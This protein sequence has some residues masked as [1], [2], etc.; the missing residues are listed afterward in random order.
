MHRHGR[1]GYLLEGHG[2]R[3]YCEGVVRTQPAA[4]VD[5]GAR[6]LDVVDVARGI[7]EKLRPSGSDQ[8][9]VA[10]V[11]LRTQGTLQ[12]LGRD[13]EIRGKRIHAFRT[14][15]VEQDPPAHDRLD[16]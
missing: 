15:Y 7:F 5:A 9:D 10:R 3:T 6:S 11:D 2:I 1:G 4:S 14:R 12:M 8:N 13:H 16:R